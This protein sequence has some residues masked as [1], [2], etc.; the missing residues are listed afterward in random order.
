MKDVLK[1]LLKKEGYNV[2]EYPCM[3]RDAA[4]STFIDFGEVDFEDVETP[5]LYTM[6]RA[7]DFEDYIDFEYEVDPD[8]F[9][10]CETLS[11]YFEK[12]F[13]SDFLDEI[14]EYFDD[15]DIDY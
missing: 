3:I 2:Y 5:G 11:Q 9:E 1:E 6:L 10:G 8:D 7:L 15:I 12:V 14:F 4:K 13:K